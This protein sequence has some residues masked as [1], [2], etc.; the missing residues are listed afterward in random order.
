VGGSGLLQ[1]LECSYPLAEGD[2]LCAGKIQI[3]L[4]H[5]TKENGDLTNLNRKGWRKS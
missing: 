1:D 3:F 5:C 4:S 2:D